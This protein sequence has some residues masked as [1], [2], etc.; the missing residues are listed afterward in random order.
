MIALIAIPPVLIVLFSL[1]LGKAFQARFPTRWWLLRLGLVP[2]IC[3]GLACYVMATPATIP[4][5]YDP[6]LR[7]NGGRLD[8]LAILAWGV[9]L[10]TI[11]VAAAFPASF[12]YALWKSRVLAPLD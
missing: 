7:G 10:P 12:A 3:L 11:Y 9:V 8:F 5:N 4:H 2:L 1:L 6:D